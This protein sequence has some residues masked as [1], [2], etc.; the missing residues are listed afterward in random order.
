MTYVR[1]KLA[2]EGLP[3]GAVLEV[4]LKGQE[5]L[6]NVP[7]SAR[8]DGHEVLSLDAQADGTSRLILRARHGGR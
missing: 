3:D 6:K 4:R 5:P 7:R 2:L 1:V 8:E